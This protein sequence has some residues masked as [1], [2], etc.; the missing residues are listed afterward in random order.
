M[1]ARRSSFSKSVV[2]AQTSPRSNWRSP[3]DP[4]S[5]PAGRASPASS[6]SLLAGSWPKGITIPKARLVAELT[7]LSPFEVRCV[8]LEPVGGLL[9]RRQYAARTPAP[10]RLGFIPDVRRQANAIVDRSR[11]LY[12]QPRRDAMKEVIFAI[13]Y[14]N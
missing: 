4:A 5:G 6:P 14:L 12:A 1:S 13:R 11:R 2:P 8:L 7:N 3:P 9:R 10:V